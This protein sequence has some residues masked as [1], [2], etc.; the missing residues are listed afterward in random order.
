MPEIILT[1]ADLNPSGVGCCGAC[2]SRGHLENEDPE[3]VPELD[4]EALAC[5]FAETQDHRDGL[6]RHWLRTR[7][8]PGA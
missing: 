6:V 2:H 5:C 3:P 1:C 8:A 7:E 4:C